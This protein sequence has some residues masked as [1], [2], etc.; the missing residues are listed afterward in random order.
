VLSESL[1]EVTDPARW[2]SAVRARLSQAEAFHDSLHA[3]AKTGYLETGKLKDRTT[4]RPYASRWLND[5]PLEGI[6]LD[7]ISFAC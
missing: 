6:A 3:H 4:S 7:E 5:E 1:R 2:N